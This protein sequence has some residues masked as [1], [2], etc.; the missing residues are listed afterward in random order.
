[1]LT[2]PTIDLLRTLKLDGMAA[3]FAELQTQDG[4]AELT[5]AEWLAL[6]L[7]R[8]AAVRNT[9]RVQSRLRL[10]KLRH[11]QASAEDVDYRAARRLDKAPCTWPFSV[12]I[13]NVHCCQPIEAERNSFLQLG[14]PASSDGLE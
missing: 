10:A 11:G 8:E 13:L 7:D 4:S 5:H 14:L 12:A 3:A 9:R 1:M 6:L 2:H